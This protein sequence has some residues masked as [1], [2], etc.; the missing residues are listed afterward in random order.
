MPLTNL[1]YFLTWKNEEG[2]GRWTFKT[3]KLA[4]NA[5]QKQLAEVL[6]LTYTEFKKGGYKDTYTREEDFD[7]DNYSAWTRGIHHQNHDWV[8]YTVEISNALPETT[9]TIK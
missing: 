4:Q 5:M 2:S 8:I 3:L 1:Q 7:F 6:S 9:I